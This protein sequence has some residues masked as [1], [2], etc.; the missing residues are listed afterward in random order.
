M[1][2]KAWQRDPSKPDTRIRGRKGQELR[3]RRLARSNY[4]CEHCQAAGRLAPATVVNHIVPLAHGGLDLDDNTENLCGPC[5]E[6]ATAKQ[7]GYRVRR[8]FGADGW[9]TDLG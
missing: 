8:E 7:F 1:A 4:L 3:K 2:R 6:I 9:P 5:D